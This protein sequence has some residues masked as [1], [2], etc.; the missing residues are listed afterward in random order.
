MAV[1]MNSSDPNAVKKQTNLPLQD[2]NN[3]NAPVPLKQ[4]QQNTTAP[5]IQPQQVQ[6]VSTPQSQTS[7]LASNA[8]QNASNQATAGFNSPTATQTSQL[9]QKLLTD[10]NQGYNPQQA[11][12]SG[13]TQYDRSVADALEVARQGMVGASGS[14]VAQSGLQDLALRTAEGRSDVKNELEQSA[15]ERTTQNMLNALAAGQTTTAMEQG[16]NSQNLNNV[17]NVLNAAE[18][19]LQREENAINR[20]LEIA[21]VNQNAELQGYLTELQGKI[22]QGLQTNKQDFEAVQNALDR[23]IARWTSEGNWNNALEAIN[24]KGEIDAVAQESAQRW[25][26]GERVAT[27]VWSTGERLSQNDFTAAE[28]YLDR[29]NKKAIADGDNETQK[30]VAEK[31]AELQLKMQTNEMEHDE[32]MSYL[33]MMYADA[34]ANKDA[35]RQKSILQFQSGLKIAEMEKQN[36]YDMA[37]EELRADTQTAIAEGNNETVTANLKAELEYRVNKDIE[38]RKIEWAANAL[39]E[40]GLDMQVYQQQL[41][42]ID[43]MIE[44]YGIDP[45]MKTEFVKATLSGQGIDTSQFEQV[46]ITT[47]AQKALSADFDMQMF[48]FGITHPEYVDQETGELNSEGLQKFNEYFNEYMY[49]ELSPEKKEERRVAGYLGADDLAFAQEGDKY[50]INEPTTYNGLTIPPGE[51]SVIET[52]ETY[53]SK[54]FG[55]KQST[56]RTKLVN[57]ET[58][59][60]FQVDKSQSGT[61]GNIVSNLWAG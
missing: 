29:L 47:E 28:S 17:L 6:P 33:D 23:D 48:Q 22:N 10:P 32:K 18:P 16:I 57:V 2:P 40:K 36:G 50:K 30:W 37:I 49:G 54:F 51:Y 13:L 34:L 44:N 4:P 11:V 52:K 38:D 39:Q 12:Q 58:G 7:Q 3:P 27:Q 55:T 25:Q 26:T 60:E 41:D 24:L 43:D 35:V 53:G 45:A 46:D 42:T 9:T 20:G 8:L 61:E 56:F 19:Q 59:E 21:K 15:N 14:S 1:N 31:N 5:T